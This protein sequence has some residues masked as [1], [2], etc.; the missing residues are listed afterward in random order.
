[1]QDVF[2]ILGI[3]PFTGAINQL[4]RKLMMKTDSLISFIQVLLVT[5]LFSACAQVSKINSVKPENSAE[6]SARR[7]MLI[8][9]WYSEIPTKDGLIRKSLMERRRDGS[10][11]VRFQLFKGATKT[12]DQIEAGIWGIS[13]NIYFTATR[14]MLVGEVFKTLDTTDSTFYDGYEILKLEPDRFT[15]KSLEMGDVFEVRKVADTFKLQ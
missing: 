14:E 6:L 13:G 7:A 1:M 15:Y 5:L 12:L 11:T 9:K 4:S 8:G 2:W 10:Y 3:R